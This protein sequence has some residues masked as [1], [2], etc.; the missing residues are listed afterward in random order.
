[1]A[2]PPSKRINYKNREQQAV[3]RSAQERKQVLTTVVNL[4]CKK[5]IEIFASRSRL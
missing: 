4:W 2:R 3:K 1:M 5:K